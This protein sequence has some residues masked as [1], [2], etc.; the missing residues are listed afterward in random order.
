MKISAFPGLG[1]LKNNATQVLHNACI[2]GKLSRPLAIESCGMSERT[3]RRLPAQLEKL[4]SKTSSRS[5]IA[6]EIPDHAEPWYF[7]QLTPAA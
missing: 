7:Q 1:P 6:W 5:D 2:F 4:L 3:A